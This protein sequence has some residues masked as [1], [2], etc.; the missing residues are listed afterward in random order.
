MGGERK[1]AIY[2]I[3]VEYGGSIY[4]RLQRHITDTYADVIIVEDDPYY[5]LQE[6]DYKPKSERSAVSVKHNADKFLSSLAPSFLKFDYQ[7][8]V[9]RLD[10]FSKVGFFLLPYTLRCL[11]EFD[12]RWPPVADLDGSPAALN[13]QR[14]WRGRARPQHRPLA[15]LVKYVYFGNHLRTYTSLTYFVVVFDHQTADYMAI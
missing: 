9:I 6:G 1:K 2:D 12:R 5:F 3:C 8:R 15:A 4:E 7:G 10:T 14:D 11:H 13:F